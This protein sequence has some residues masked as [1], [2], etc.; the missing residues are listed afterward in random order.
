MVSTWLRHLAAPAMAAVLLCCGTAFAADTYQANLGP[1]PLDAANRANMLGRGDATA[2]LDGKTLTVSGT[3][4]GLPSPATA[5][6]LIVGLAIGVPGTETLGLTVSQADKGSVSGTLSLDRQTGRR[7]PHRQALC[8][9]RQPEG[10]HRHSVGLAVAATC[11]CAGRCA[12]AGTLVPAAAQHA[13]PL[14]RN[15]SCRF[16]AGKLRAGMA[17]AAVVSLLGVGTA[18]PQA[19]G[20]FTAAQAGAGHAAY[21]ENCA[22]CH[23][24]TLQGGGEAPALVG[25][26]F[27]SSWGKRGADELY[28]VIKASMPMGNPSSLPPET[29]QQIVAFI[30]QANGAAPGAA[31]FTGEAKDKIASFATGKTPAGLLDASGRRARPRAGARRPRPRA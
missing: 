1:M 23:N 12:P 22:A 29:Y 4:A 9:D 8:P 17:T 18:A 30:L 14:A 19:A 31:P 27:I 6:H 3:F 10:A 25:S 13:H 7:L 24:R 21:L 15:A 26:A 2:I 11:R 28:G 20:P 16:S 5:A